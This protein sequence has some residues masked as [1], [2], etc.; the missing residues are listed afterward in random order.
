MP[1]WK[2][3]K[4]GKLKV[5]CFPNGNS[6]DKKRADNTNMQRKEKDKIMNST[7][8]SLKDRI[9]LTEAT[10]CGEYETGT[11]RKHTVVSWEF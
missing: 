3:S 9:G 7:N 4:S 1:P 6:G 2:M 8:K 11:A 10:E 5:N